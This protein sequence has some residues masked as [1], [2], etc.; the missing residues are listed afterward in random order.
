MTNMDSQLT[1]PSIGF[2][3]AMRHLVLMKETHGRQQLKK[4]P[5]NLM[6]ARWAVDARAITF[7]HT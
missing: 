2:D 4:R 3:V 5:C 7:L 1:K 6:P